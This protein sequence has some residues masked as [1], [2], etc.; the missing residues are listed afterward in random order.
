MSAK[1]PG[2]IRAQVARVRAAEREVLM[3]AGVQLAAMIECVGDRRDHMTR[4]SASELAR[5][6]K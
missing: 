2:V 5:D 3:G 1:A 6:R 4:Q